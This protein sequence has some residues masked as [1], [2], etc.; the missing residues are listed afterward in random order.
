M[1]LS[2]QTLEGSAR[3]FH[4]EAARQGLKLWHGALLP[5]A[6]AGSVAVIGHILRPD[7]PR[8]DNALIAQR[9][10]ACTSFSALED[11]LAVLSGR[12]IVIAEIGG[13]RRLYPDAAGSKSVFYER[14]Q[15]ASH[16]ALLGYPADTSLAAY[17]KAATWPVGIT[18]YPGVRQL[19]PNHYLDLTTFQAVRFGPRA[20]QSISLDQAVEIIG[21]SLRGTIEA[22]VQRGETALPVTAGHD[23]RTLVS[24]SVG[25]PLRYFTVIDERT[26]HHDLAIPKA[27]ANRLRLSWRYV[28]SVSGQPETLGGLWQDPNSDRLNGFA[29][30][31]FIVLGHISEV[32]RCF[33]W[34]SGQ[35]RA[36]TPE[37]LADQS[38]LADA[39]VLPAI[40]EWLA[41]IPEG[42]DPWDMWY[43]ENRAGCWSSLC[44]SVFDLI[45]D[46]VS[47]WNSRAV[48]D[49]G[50]GVDVRYRAAP[51]ELHQR[52]C[53]PQLRTLPFN[54]TW[55]ERATL[56][57]RVR[58]FMRRR[59]YRAA[60]RA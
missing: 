52:L 47:P 2:T 51:Y 26:P 58:Q 60:R 13:Q 43:W 42:I 39:P 34:K 5:V 4:A 31:P 41:A 7:A 12:W 18:P 40:G 53:L 59:A 21:R 55:L 10:A 33:Y 30:A 25:L 23:S 22:I 57:W 49:A 54:S 14:G 11:Q 35:E 15:F 37:A 16:P 50:L 19:L 27:I 38:R 32:C 8:D 20:P 17:P 28:E 44:C 29:Q 6:H 24:A 48:L 3:Y 56:P 45:C 46:V 1:D 36:A 9:L